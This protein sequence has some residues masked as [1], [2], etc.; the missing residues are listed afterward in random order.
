MLE[1]RKLQSSFIWNL[2]TARM[3]GKR[4][5]INTCKI[6]SRLSIHVCDI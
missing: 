1:L 6:V 4:F 5:E 3:Q 2:G